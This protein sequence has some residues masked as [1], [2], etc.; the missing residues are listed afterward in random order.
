MNREKNSRFNT[1]APIE[2]GRKL[3]RSGV[4]RI[5]HAYACG[6]EIAR[7]PRQDRHGMNHRCRRD[8]GVPLGLGM[9]TW[10]LAHRRATSVSSGST[11]PANA[12]MT[13]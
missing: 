13:R 2:C 10:R 11:R 12:G 4:P 9:G 1:R 3:A 6:H 5:D 8:Q 7:V